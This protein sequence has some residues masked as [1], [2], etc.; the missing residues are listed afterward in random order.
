MIA[1]IPKKVIFIFLFFNFIQSSKSAEFHNTNKSNIN[2][3]S[4]FGL[5]NISNK[6]IISNPYKLSHK[7]NFD[8]ISIDEKLL[9]QFSEKLLSDNSKTKKEIIIKS[10]KQSEINDVIFAE[11]NVSLSYKGKL[12]KADNLIYDKFNKKIIAKGNI[13]LI[14]GDQI[15][16][17]SHLEYSFIS[18]KGFLLDVKGYIN[19]NSLM[20][21]LSSNF[22]LSDYENLENLLEFKK[23]KVLN[24]PDKVEIVPT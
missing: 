18:E 13:E 19:T 17:S 11:G 6:K 22:T 12:L 5:S 24:T 16:K 10:D 15:L 3:T 2:L 20:E 21:D 23:K 14:L 9:N 8:I 7:N 4:K 1:G